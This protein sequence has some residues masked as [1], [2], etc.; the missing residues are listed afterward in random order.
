MMRMPVKTI[1]ITLEAY[2]ALLKLKRPGESFSDVILRLARRIL[3][4]SSSSRGSGE[5]FLRRR[6]RRF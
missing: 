4:T 6:L 1:T 2:E 5:M 3:Q